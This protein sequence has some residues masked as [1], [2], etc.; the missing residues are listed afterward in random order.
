MVYL[1]SLAVKRHAL[2]GLF[3]CF[4]TYSTAK[5]IS[6]QL[7]L[8]CWAEQMW[9]TL[10]HGSNLQLSTRL[11]PCVWRGDFNGDGRADLA[12]FITHTGSKRK[13]SPFCCKA[14]RPSLSARAQTSETVAT[15]SL[16]WIPG[17]WKIAAPSTATTGGN[18]LA[19]NQ[20]AWSLLQRKVLRAH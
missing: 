15:I 2:A 3:L 7:Q 13:A 1:F 9:L 8:P 10:S 20:T 5:G 14:R 12:L 4:A 11:N 18:R 16:G 17:M 19:C 6:P